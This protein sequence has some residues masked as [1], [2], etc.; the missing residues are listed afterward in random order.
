MTVHPTRLRAVTHLGI[1]DDD[2]ERAV[3]LIPR[4]LGA[5]ARA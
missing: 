5:L 3:E 2:V 4:A 1:G